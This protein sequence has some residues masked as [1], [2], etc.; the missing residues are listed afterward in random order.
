VKRADRMSEP[1]TYRC[2]V[3]SAAPDFCRVK[4]DPDEGG[5]KF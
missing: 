4:D 5:G 1:H 3:S 2:G